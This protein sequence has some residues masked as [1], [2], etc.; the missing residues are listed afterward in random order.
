MS[1]VGCRMSDVGCRMSENWIPHPKPRQAQ[2]LTLR[3]RPQTPDVRLAF[4]RLHIQNQA[5]I[6]QL[7]AT[8]GHQLTLTRFNKVVAKFD[9][10]A[11][12]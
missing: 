7:I 5:M 1:D 11:R 2:P 9:D 6:N 8:L 3:V 4:L 10:L 12:F